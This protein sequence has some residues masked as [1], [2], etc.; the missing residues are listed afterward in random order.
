MALPDGF[1]WALWEAKTGCLPHSRGSTDDSGGRHR[2][3]RATP[4]SCRPCLSKHQS[5][6]VP[7][8]E[9]DRLRSIVFSELAIS[10][11]GAAVFAVFLL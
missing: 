6:A 5:E 8:T 10:G 4:L 1:W 3:A 2:I 9:M 7:V 11:F